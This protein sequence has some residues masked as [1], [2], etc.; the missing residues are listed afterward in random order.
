M[1]TPNQELDSETKGGDDLRDRQSTTLVVAWMS[2]PVLEIAQ[3]S[4]KMKLG[5]VRARAA[6]RT[7]VCTLAWPGR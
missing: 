7:A 4:Q 1:A 2:P 5:L 6:A 3:V